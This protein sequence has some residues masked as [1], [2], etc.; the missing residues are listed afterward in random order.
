MEQSQGLRTRNRVRQ[1]QS[2]GSAERNSVIV[3]FTELLGIFGPVPE[4]DQRLLR[5]LTSMKRGLA[6]VVS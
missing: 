2:F 3:T 1:P 6:H 4:I 5:G